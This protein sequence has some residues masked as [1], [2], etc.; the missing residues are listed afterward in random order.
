MRADGRHTLVLWVFICACVSQ[1][2]LG[3]HLAEAACAWRPQVWRHNAVNGRME[4]GRETRRWQG[5]LRAPGQL[6]SSGRPSETRIPDGQG[7][8]TRKIGN[9]GLDAVHLHARSM[10]RCYPAHAHTHTPSATYKQI[11]QITTGEDKWA[12]C[13]PCVNKH[14]HSLQCTSRLPPT[15]LRCCVSCLGSWQQTAEERGN[16]S[17][18]VVHAG[19]TSCPLLSSAALTLH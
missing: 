2:V 6:Y 7:E 9:G 16:R 5:L 19:Q 11:T 18:W 17:S 14:H 8:T 1:L 3:T 10:H 12:K 15:P 4:G 13:I